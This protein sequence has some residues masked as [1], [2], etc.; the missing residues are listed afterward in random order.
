[1]SL[2]ITLLSTLAAAAALACASTAVAGDVTITL[3]GVQARGGTMLVALQSRDQF[4]QPAAV[5]GGMQANPQAGTVTLTLR[6]V[7]AGE[8]ALSALHD[9]NG[10]HQMARQPDGRPLEGWAM[11]RVG[12]G[13]GHRPTFD[14]ARISVPAEGAQVTAAMVY[15]ASQ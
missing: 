10:D 1:M 15:P 3:T 7:P 14:E 5:V 8:Y 13:I 12:A 4:M 2:R 11:S 6:N 9:A